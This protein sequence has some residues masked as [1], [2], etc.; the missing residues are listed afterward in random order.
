M[1][2]IGLGLV[3]AL[4]AGLTISAFGLIGYHAINADDL[5]TSIGI[6]ALGI[7]LI[8]SFFLIFG[9][10]GFGCGNETCTTYQIPMSKREIEER[11]CEARRVSKL[12]NNDMNKRK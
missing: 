1:V 11:Q 12:W 9:L 10:H 2:K 3:V 6:V 8:A 7:V 5:C 4:V